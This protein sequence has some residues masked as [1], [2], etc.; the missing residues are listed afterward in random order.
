MFGL[1][2]TEQLATTETG[3]RNIGEHDVIVLNVE[4]G[5]RLLGSVCGMTIVFFREEF[6][7]RFAYEVVVIDDQDCCH[8]AKVSEIEGH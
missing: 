5:K 6:V 8:L 4:I 3:H 2:V 1:N 7:K